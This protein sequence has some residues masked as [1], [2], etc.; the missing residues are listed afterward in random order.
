VLLATGAVFFLLF[1]PALDTC[2]D[3]REATRSRSFLV[4]RAVHSK[5]ARLA[6]STI[7]AMVFGVLEFVSHRVI[8][9]IHIDPEMHAFWDGVIMA[10][11][12]AL[13]AWLLLS[14]R[15]DQPVEMHGSRRPALRPPTYREE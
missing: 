3:E 8:T 2:T 1:D 12:G 11:G 5:S 14:G 7:I 4:G 9:S 15:E 13:M 10:L 6:T